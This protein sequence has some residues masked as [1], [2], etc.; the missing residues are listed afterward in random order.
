MMARVFR[1]TSRALAV[2]ETVFATTTDPPDDAVAAYCESA[3]LPYFRGSLYDVLERLY[4]AARRTEADVV[5]RVTADCP[6][7]DPG[8]IDNVVAAVL[9]GGY[10]LACNR[11]PPPWHRTYPIGL[12]AEA[13]TFAAL[14]RA[15]DE[16]QAPQHREHAMPYL[17]E[18]VNLHAENLTLETGT[19]PRGF[20]IALLHSGRELGAHR[21]TVDTA[22]D[23]EF[24]RQ[25][26][27]HFDGRDDFT[28]EEVLNLMH[29]RPELMEINA[30]VEHKTLKDIDERLLR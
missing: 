30:G 17:Y 16:A 4:Q 10:D 7:I 12:D 5:V 25:I 11:L 8:L 13:C 20:R 2:D 29:T 9:Q 15:R 24:I 27:K 28:W 1:R 21:W 23:L 6:L 18:N 26:Y 3:N 19:S 14:E 22:A